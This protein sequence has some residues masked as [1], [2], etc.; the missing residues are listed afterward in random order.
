M[1]KELAV[2]LLLAGFIGLVIL[3][4]VASWI[5][6]V[7]L[8]FQTH[9]GWGAAVLLA[10]PWGSVAFAFANWERARWPALLTIAGFVGM[11]VLALSIPLLKS[12][13]LES[14]PRPTPSP[15]VSAA[16]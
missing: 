11:V 14:T 2:L 16:S 15:S 13:G 4:L 10:Y 8:A 9:P 7:V 12:A 1:D 6:M 5:W 3:S